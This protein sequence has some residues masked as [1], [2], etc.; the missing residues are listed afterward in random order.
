[1]QNDRVYPLFLRDFLRGFEGFA[2]IGIA[3]Q[4]LSALCFD[5]PMI[6]QRHYMNFICFMFHND[7]QCDAPF[8]LRGVVSGI[9]AL[10]QSGCIRFCAMG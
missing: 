7:F 10:R 5:F 3:C 9:D 8:G 6:A 2:S 1:M 4:R